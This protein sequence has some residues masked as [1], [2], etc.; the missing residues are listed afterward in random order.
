MRSFLT[1]TFGLR[2]LRTVLREQK[3][4]SNFRAPRPIQAYQQACLAP[5]LSSA[6]SSRTIATSHVQRRDDKIPTEAPV[7]DFNQLNVLGNTPAPATSVDVCMYDG[8]GLNSGVTIGEG[9][10]ALLVNGEAFEWR[11]WEAKARMELGNE[12]GQF[13]LPPEAFG[14]FEVLWPRPGTFFSLGPDLVFS[15]QT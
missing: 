6:V 3:S 10:G 15:V 8:F 4:T 7:T 12:K 9:N 2:A 5:R 1:P 14:L 11:P 13:D